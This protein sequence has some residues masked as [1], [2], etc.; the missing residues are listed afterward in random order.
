MLKRADICPL[1]NG[2][3]SIPLF[4]APSPDDTGGREYDLVQCESCK[5][6]QVR[7]LPSEEELASLY[8]HDYYGWSNV[9][10]FA[11]GLA[12]ELQRWFLDRRCRKIHKKMS[13]GR[14]LDVGCGDADFLQGMQRLGWDVSGVEPSRL[15]RKALPKTLRPLVVERLENI[16]SGPFDVITL[17]HVLEHLPS[18]ERALIKCKALLKKN[19]LL[20]VAVP[21]F[22]SWEAKLGRQR[23]FHLDIPRHLYHFTPVTIT[24]LLEKS[25][26]R[27]RRINFFSWIYNTFGLLQTLMNMVV[28]EQ[29]YLYYRWKRRTDYGAK[30]SFNRYLLYQA[31][32]YTVFPLALVAA[33]FLSG[34]SAC[35][36]SSGTME[37]EA[38]VADPSD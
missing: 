15:A 8:F 1:C 31:I 34:F 22:G 14:L 29:N 11:E 30:L 21:N 13:V 12:T 3:G 33:L 16:K 19:G 24:A 38:L 9:N 28:P 36:L 4:A 35:L 7:P 17:W 20:F 10:G 2:D 27:V 5:L 23:W 26:Y 37:V 25:G 6:V 32:N 18:P